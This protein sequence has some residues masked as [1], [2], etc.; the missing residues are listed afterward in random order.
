[1]IR[2]QIRLEDP[3]YNVDLRREYLMTTEEAAHMSSRFIIDST[4]RS[5]IESVVDEWRD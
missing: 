3:E 1:M 2:I 4:V 5:L